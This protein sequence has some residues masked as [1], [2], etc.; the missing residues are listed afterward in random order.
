MNQE[1]L[2]KGYVLIPN[3]FTND[4]IE[5]MRD[6]S[7]R[8]FKEGGGFTNAGGFAKPDYIKEDVLHPIYELIESKNLESIIQEL[9]GEVVEFTGHNDLHMNRSV[10]WHKDRLNGEARKFEIHSPWDTIDGESMKIYKVNLYL[11][12]HHS[13][14]D[15]LIVKEGNHKSESMIDGSDVTIHPNIGDIII[16]DQRINHMATYSGGY[17]RLLVCMGYG[18]RNGFFDEFKAGT[19]YRQNKQNKI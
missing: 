6:L 15:A 4:E 16:F 2:N 18:V 1:F 12:D 9:I 11:Q 7:I 5:L 19:E 14:N 3:V 17:D 8:Y 10:G 13:N